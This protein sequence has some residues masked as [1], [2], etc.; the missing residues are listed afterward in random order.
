MSTFWQRFIKEFDA[1]ILNPWNWALYFMG[2][3]VGYF[4]RGLA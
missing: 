4:L 1:F 2:I 3:S